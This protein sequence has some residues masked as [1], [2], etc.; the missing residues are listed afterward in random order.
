MKRAHIASR[1]HANT[2]Y[3]RTNPN[4]EIFHCAAV[5]FHFYESNFKFRLSLSYNLLGTLMIL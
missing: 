4:M 3:K 5:V 1:T 2:K